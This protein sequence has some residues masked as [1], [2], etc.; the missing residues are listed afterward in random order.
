MKKILAILLTLAMVL[1]LCVGV[2]AEESKAEVKPFVMVNT[3]DVGVT[4][5]NLTYKILFWSGSS[6]KYV[7]EDHI[8][9][10]AMNGVGGKTPTE[11]A[12]NLKPIFD[13]FPDG[14]RYLRLMSF[15]SALVGLLEDHIF[16]EK[17]L[18][19][20]TDWFNE[21]I[22]HYH[23]IG[24]KLDGVVVDVEFFDSFSYGLTQERIKNPY[25]YKQIIDNP[26]YAT[27]IRPQ[28]EERGFKFY[29]N[30]TDVTPEIYS[31]DGGSGDQYAQS[32]AIWNVVIRNHYNQY[33]TE[34]FAEA[35]KLYPELK[36]SDYVARTM[37][38]WDKNMSSS[39]GFTVGG[40]YYTAGN[41]NY[42]NTYG[43]RPSPSYFKD[44]GI[45]I[46]QNPPSYNDA[47]WEDNPYNMTLWELHC[48]KQLKASAPDNR[49][50]VTTV[51]Y[52]Y[53]TRTGSYCNT[54]YYSE[55][56]YHTGMLDP[57]PF[58]AYCIKSEMLH[59]G[60]DVEVAMGILSKQLDELTRVAGYA[61]REYISLPF[62]WND[63]Y[64]LS[65]MYAGGRNIWRITPD[66]YGTNTTLKSF[67][68]EGT[69]DPT[70]TIEGQTVTFPGGRIIED[71]D[72]PL[73]GTCGYWVETDKD[74][75]PVRTYAAD[76]FQQYPA[77]METYESYN[78]NSAL[79]VGQAYPMGCW[80]MKKNKDSAAMIVDS[81]NGKALA[82]AGTYSLKM[83]DILENITAGDTYAKNQVWE[84]DVSLPGNMPANAETVLM[85]IYGKKAKADDG[86]FKISGGKIFYDNAGSY[87]ELAGVDVSAGGNFKLQRKLDFNNKDAFTCTYAVYDATG[88]LLAEAKD[89]PMAQVSLPVNKIGFG[90]TNVVGTSVLLDNL[91]LY[92]NGVGADLEIYDAK[93]G[94]LQTEPDKAR[95][96]STAYRFSWMN[97]TAS[98]KVYSIVAA[99][100]N[101]D[102]LVEEKVIEEI[103]MAPGS[104]CVN[105]GIVEVAA[106]QSV[107]IY[108]R[109]DSKPDPDPNGNLPDATGPG[110]A[111]NPGGMGGTDIIM[112]CVI[113]VCAL[114]IIGSA[115]AMVLLLSKKKPG[116]AEEQVEN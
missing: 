29:P 72:I 5:D 111:S 15:R 22:T 85:D 27:K 60:A 18:K 104:D 68:V 9:V 113:I 41:S 19:L 78:A 66:T 98:E 48:A 83:K 74:V 20:W 40:N 110:A 1:P 21:F 80:E 109:D 31:V 57:D 105:T 51:Y 65:G 42:V 46:Y 17:G 116:K 93:T 56:M 2:T 13:E 25:V 101:G 54:P 10:D 95:D 84:I 70:F 114:V 102:Q 97:A 8:K 91:K 73:V 6:E 47:V 12:E 99:Y 45:P 24:G 94:I 39:D 61:D 63:K 11:V 23:S 69:Q 36:I 38:G 108:A 87:V 28:L 77:F 16:M 86:G 37:Y 106:G 71:A 62:S 49:L 32:R 96:R 103:K 35:A 55:I 4:F 14:T 90:V 43:S 53:S 26:N 115:V 76:R 3:E 67:K 88:K 34:G 52:N 30:V 7:T 64:L 58:Q 92:V 59:S 33:V 82:L 50:T 79:D 44:G 112:L 100:Y 107:K 81:G 89:I 75:M